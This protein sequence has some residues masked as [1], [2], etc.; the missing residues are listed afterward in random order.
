MTQGDPEWTRLAATIEAE[1]AAAAASH[2]EQALRQHMLDVALGAVPFAGAIS[3]APVV[4]LLSHV[5]LDD[6]SSRDDHA[7]S[8]DG[9]PLSALHPD[10]PAAPADWWRARTADLVDEFGAQHVSNSVAALFLTPWHTAV[11][12]PRLRLPS[13]RRILQIAE[14]VASRDATLVLMRGADLWIELPAIAS[15]STSRLVRA[16]SWR[17]TELTSANLGD[18][19]WDLVRRRLAVHAWLD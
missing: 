10:A 11:F 17:A 4:L 15:L 6:R 13:R 1:D 5:A 3:T 18:D 14:S 2:N 12:D 16:R 19:A 7:F 8:R 9:W